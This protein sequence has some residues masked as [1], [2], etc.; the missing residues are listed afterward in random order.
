ML[1][2]QEN[3]E[4]MYSILAHAKVVIASSGIIGK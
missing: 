1:K 4:G 2:T 3:N